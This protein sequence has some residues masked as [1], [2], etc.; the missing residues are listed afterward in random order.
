MNLTQEELFSEEFS[1]GRQTAARDLPRILHRPQHT[2]QDVLLKESLVAVRLAQGTSDINDVREKLATALPQ[3]SQVT[4]LRYV[5]SVIRWFFRDGARGF[6][7]TVWEKFQSD[8]IQTAIHRYLY[9]AAEPIIGTCV[10]AV[11][12]RLSEGV[13]VPGDYLAGATAKLLGHGLSP[14]TK[15]R[16]LSNLRKLGFL[17]RSAA[18]DRVVSPAVN[19][20][21]LLIALHHAFDVNRQRSIEFATLAANPFWRF[22]GLRSEDGL[23]D[24]L[25]EAV[26]AGYL[27]KYVVA[28]RLE[29]VTTCLTLSELLERGV[30]L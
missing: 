13:L 14:Q 30:R 11:L 27:G 20:S 26:H 9:L 15:K 23:R 28:D 2:L 22:I 18:G 5:D 19:K 24:F 12:S 29:Q 10:A 25:K 7:T 6:A 17:E 3:N 8:A 1:H 16:L 4:R 21:A